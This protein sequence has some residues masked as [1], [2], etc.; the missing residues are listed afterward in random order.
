LL[1]VLNR[2]LIILI[3]LVLLVSASAVL[4]TALGVTQPAQVAP[5]GSWFVDRLAPFAS[6]DPTLLGWT[7][8]VTLALVLVAL[9]L[10]FLELRVR[11][12]AARRITLKE[13]A[14]GRVTVALDGVRELVD[15]EAGRVAG[16]TRA[17]SEVEEDDKGLR[18]VCRISV[19]PES[20]VPD[21]TQEL[22]ERLKTTVEHHVGLAVTQVS[23]DAQVA[24]P[25]IN[26]RHRRRVE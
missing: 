2:L 17:R 21:M 4:L 20:S 5:A 24:S 10:L 1:T 14:L 8:G 12:R 13:D 7:V 6:L 26:Q 15:R 3:A 11:P 9:V 16:V 23:V 25:V 19:D 22:R 18:I